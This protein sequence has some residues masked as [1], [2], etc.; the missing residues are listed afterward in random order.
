MIRY[1]A[2]FTLSRSSSLAGGSIVLPISGG[3]ITWDKY[4]QSSPSEAEST[5]PAIHLPSEGRTQSG[6]GSRVS[7]RAGSRYLRPLPPLVFQRGGLSCDGLTLREDIALH[8]A[9]ESMITPK[10]MSFHNPA[11]SV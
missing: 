5:S 1:S 3:S 2:W 9:I 10:I 7:S 8:A 6:Y 4:A 11:V